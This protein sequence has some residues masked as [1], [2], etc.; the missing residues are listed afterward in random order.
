MR[1]SFFVKLSSYS[2]IGLAF[3]FSKSFGAATLNT[4][5]LAALKK[6]KDR[7]EAEMTELG[8]IR[9]MASKEAEVSGR[10]TG[11]EKKMHYNDIEKVRDRPNCETNM[12]PVP[13]EK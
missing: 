7:Y 4:P 11:C 6:D 9:D 3:P 1:I 13:C 5:W 8:S 10:I 12:G 2:S